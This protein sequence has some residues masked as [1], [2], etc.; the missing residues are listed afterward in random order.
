M[1]RNGPSAE[2]QQHLLVLLGGCILTLAGQLAQAEHSL[3][4]QPCG[5]RWGLAVGFFG[6][7]CVSSA[8]CWIC[9]SLGWCQVPLQQLRYHSSFLAELHQP[10][11]GA[12]GSSGLS[13]PSALGSLPFLLCLWAWLLSL[14]ASMCY[15]V[16]RWDRGS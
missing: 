14:S 13:H 2:E 3:P 16:S 11:H 7:L 12:W 9:S 6:C 8:D 10:S 15:T 1:C 4:Q 5:D